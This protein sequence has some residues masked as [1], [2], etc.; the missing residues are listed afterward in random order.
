MREVL[1]DIVD[2]LPK[3]IDSATV[4][5]VASLLTLITVIIG[6]LFAFHKWKKDVALRRAEYINELTEKIRTDSAI[7]EAIYLFDYGE[8]WYSSS[9]HNS[10]DFELKIDKTL[11]YFSYICY[12]K[13]KKIISKSEFSFFEYEILRTLQNE[14]VQDYLFNIY[15]FAKKFKIPVTFYYL[16]EYGIKH[17]IFNTDFTDKSS[18]DKPTSIYHKNLN[19]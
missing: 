15:H 12:L 18:C 6:G 19:F 8:Q 11:S 10:G 1:D 2:W 16:V 13:H 14:Q 3:A 7:R 4:S 9:F 17:N 5:D